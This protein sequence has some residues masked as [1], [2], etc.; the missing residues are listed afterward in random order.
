MESKD[1]LAYFVEEI[2][3]T[4]V[5]TVDDAG[6]PVTAAIDM[7]D[8]D[9]NGI[10]FLTARGKGFYDRLKKRGVLALTSMKGEDTMRFS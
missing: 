5:A 9:E 6:Q 10:Y 8:T 2:H 1:Y 4:V 7:M 3:T